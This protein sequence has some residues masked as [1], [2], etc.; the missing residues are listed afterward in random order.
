MENKFKQLCVWPGTLMGDADAKEFESFFQVEFGVRVKFAEEVV[1]NGSI[2]RNEEGGRHDILFYIHEDDI[3]KFAAPRL[4]VGIR[5]WEDVVS[6]ND[7]SYLYNEE[8]LN[9]YPI[10]W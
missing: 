7:N 6:Y 8:V 1:T 3:P 4:S 10:T 5:W 2:E 9:K